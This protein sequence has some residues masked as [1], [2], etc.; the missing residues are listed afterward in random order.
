MFSTL[1]V[2]RSKVLANLDI[3]DFEF[4]QNYIQFYDKLERCNSRLE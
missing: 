4:S 1:N 3:D 2:L